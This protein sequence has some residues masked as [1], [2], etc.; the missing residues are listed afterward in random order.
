METSYFPWKIRGKLRTHKMLYI[1]S[2]VAESIFKQ[3]YH[4]GVT[5]NIFILNGMFF[6]S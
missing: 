4:L 6:Q 2:E 3:T 5:F 1:F